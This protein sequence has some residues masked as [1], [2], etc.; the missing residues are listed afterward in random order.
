M[1]PQRFNKGAGRVVLVGHQLRR[2]GNTNTCHVV[3]A[4]A[5]LLLYREQLAV[6]KHLLLT[7]HRLIPI[8]IG[9]ETLVAVILGG[10]GGFLQVEA[11]A[12]LL[13]G[14][15]L[16][17]GFLLFHLLLHRLG[18]LVDTL[19]RFLQLLV[20]LERLAL[21]LA[22]LL[23]LTLHLLDGG[24]HSTQ[25]TLALLACDDLCHDVFQTVFHAGTFT[26]LL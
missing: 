13:L 19:L 20:E 17:L 11:F 16:V 23:V 6:L 8:I 24:V 7:E 22:H 14:G 4:V 26:G 1:Q 21:A 12:L 3:G 10:F 15:S 18:V 9:T 5:T 2:I 25:M